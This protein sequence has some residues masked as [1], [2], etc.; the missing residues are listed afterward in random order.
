ME[1]TRNPIPLEERLLTRDLTTEGLAFWGVVSGEL[2]MAEVGKIMETNTSGNGVRSLMA[3]RLQD[4]LGLLAGAG[5]LNPA[6]RALPFDAD[7]RCLRCGTVH[8][9]HPLLARSGASC[10]R[11]LWGTVPPNTAGMC[12]GARR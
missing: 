9:D 11:D 3:H 2:T 8:A 12:R 10:F 7:R 4:L 6:T 5:I 1:A